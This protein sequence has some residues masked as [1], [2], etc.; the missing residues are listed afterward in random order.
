VLTLPVD[1][2]CTNT[3]PARHAELG[4]DAATLQAVRPELI[5]ACISAMGLDHPDVPGYDPVL[6]AHCGFMDLTG[7]PDGPPM[8]CGPPL[9]DLK[10]GDEAFTQVILAM[11]ERQRTGRGSIVD[12]SMARAAVSWLH[13][14]LPMLD[15]GSPPEELRRS[16][17][18][19]RQFIPVNAY[20]TSDG[21]VF[22]AVGS[23][24]QWERLTATGMFASLAREE[25]ATNEGR[26]AH[27]VQLHREIGA[28][29]LEH[30]QA[31]V[32][33]ALER[34]QV[35]HAPITRV[36]Q[37][38]DLPFVRDAALS[39]EAPDGRIIRLPPPAA[40][41]A[42]LQS[43]GGRL[44]F[45]PDYGEHTRAVLEE[46]GLDRGEIADLEEEGVIA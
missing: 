5:W 16:G 44:P 13:T 36:E 31:Q 18:E 2:F 32:A 20:A 42:H 21:H 1:V 43:I 3:M 46:A 8:Q 28:I 38:M 9:I 30:T 45:A 7:E 4:V 40:A 12:I 14:F 23:D 25:L 10:A 29:T 11:L 37:V 35:P 34:A 33:A 26:R 27:R 6:Q 41:T 17:N 39:T 15:M 22:V 19:H 24:A